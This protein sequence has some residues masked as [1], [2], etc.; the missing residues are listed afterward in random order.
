[1][2][3]NYTIEQKESSWL[4]REYKD[5]SGKS[6]IEYHTPIKVSKYDE[7]DHYYEYVDNGNSVQCIRCGLGHKIVLGI[8]KIENGKI[9]NVVKRI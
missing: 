5:D 3:E 9:V 2:E 1:M 4:W 8:H 6:S 7:C